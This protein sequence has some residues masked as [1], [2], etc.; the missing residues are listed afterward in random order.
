MKKDAKSLEQPLHIPPGFDPKQYPHYDL[1]SSIYSLLLSALTLSTHYEKYPG[2]EK[3]Q[4]DMEQ[5]LK[6]YLETCKQIEIG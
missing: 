5:L 2:V 3:R 4:K 6:A 1:Q